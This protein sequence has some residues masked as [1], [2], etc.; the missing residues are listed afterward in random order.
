MAPDWLTEFDDMCGRTADA[1]SLTV[2]EL[3]RLVSRCKARKPRIE[4]LRER[5][6]RSS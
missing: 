3:T 6:G 1:R 4:K 5:R 2:D